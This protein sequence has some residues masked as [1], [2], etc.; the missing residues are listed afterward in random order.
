VR[1]AG[2]EGSV[3][4]KENGRWEARFSYEDADTGEMKR[5]SVSG[6]TRAEALRKVRE[7]RDRTAV[8]APVTDSKVTLAAWVGTW[9]STTLAASDRKAT[10]KEL[11]KTIA[12]RHL[13]VGTLAALRL[14]EIRPRHV[15]ALILAMRAKYAD[16]TIRS[17][18][19]VLRSVLDGAVRDGLLARNP[20]A[21]VR[22]PGIERKEAHVLEPVDVRR[23]LA[24]CRSSRYHRPLLLVAAT[25]MRRG[26]ALALRW[27]DVDLEAGV[28]IVRGTLARIEGELRVT[29]P[30]TQRSRRIVPLPASV[31]AALREQRRSQ[32]AERLAAANWWSDADYV[33][34][35]ETGAP[36]DPRNLLRV[37]QVAGRRL[38]LEGVGVHTLRHS[39][40]SAALDAGAN[41]KTISDLL[42]HSSIAITGDLYL[43]NTDRAQRAA[44]ES[45]AA[46]L[47]F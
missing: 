34:T 27:R 14:D 25:G 20:A 16:S 13:A 21:Q 22:R 33:F 45:V 36:V 38:G 31:V 1:R 28:A 10:T 46:A 24:E 26:E 47:G 30:K 37:V 7:A 4:Q 44:S 42:G 29:E 41:I 39:A 8:G 5:G 23:L 18:Y 35:T 17:V 3:R 32:A 19:T 11:Y 40:A 6:K 12:M 9:C 43:H 2:G 15:E